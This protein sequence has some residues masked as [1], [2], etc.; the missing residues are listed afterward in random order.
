M[1]TRLHE[2]LQLARERR[3]LTLAAIARQWGVREQNLILIERDAFEDL[4]TGLYGRNAV[5]AYATAVGVPV[6][7]ALAEV[8]ERLRAPEDPMEGL[9]RVHGLSYSTARR[10][11]SA[12]SAPEFFNASL[13]AWRPHAAA[14]LDAAVLLSF[15]L[16]LLELTALVAG[17]RA[18]DVLRTGAPWLV[19]LFTLIAVLYFVL[20]GGIAR[21]TFGSRLAHAA[22]ETAMFESVMRMLRL[23]RV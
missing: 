20:L 1:C 8:A 23:R 9:A 15:D 14:G 16:V 11:E 4:P 2:R 3:G 18:S 10:T 12:W 5:R 22:V 13:Q 7:E 21:L 17:V 19:L 6:D